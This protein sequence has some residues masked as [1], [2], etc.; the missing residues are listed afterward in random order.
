MDNLEK[1]DEIYILS[2]EEVEALVKQGYKEALKWV[3]TAVEQFPD[4]DPKQLLTT[5]FNLVE[6]EQTFDDLQ[7]EHFADVTVEPP[8]PITED[9]I[10]TGGKKIL[11]TTDADYEPAPV[12][13][14]EETFTDGV[15]SFTEA[16]VLDEDGGSI[17]DT[18][19]ATYGIELNDDSHGDSLV[20]TVTP[21]V[22]DIIPTTEETVETISEEDLTQEETVDTPEPENV[23]DEIV[24]QI[25]AFDEA[26]EKSVYDDLKEQ[27]GINFNIE[28]TENAESLHQEEVETVE[29]E[30]TPEDGLSEEKEEEFDEE[31]EALFSELENEDDVNVAEETTEEEPQESNDET[32]ESETSIF[33]SMMSEYGLTLDTETVEGNIVEEETTGKEDIE[34]E[35]LETTEDSDSPLDAE[36][37][38]YQDGA[39]EDL[40]DSSEDEDSILPTADLEDTDSNSDSQS[41]NGYL[42]YAEG[43]NDEIESSIFDSMMSEYGLNLDAETVEEE[44]IEDLETIESEHSESA[45]ELEE[46]TDEELPYEDEATEEVETEDDVEDSIVEEETTDEEL[47]YEDEA[48]EEV[49]T[50]DAELPVASEMDETLEA[51]IGDEFDSEE[52]ETEDDV[53]DSIVKEETTDEELPYEDGATEE[54][55]TEDA[56]LPAASEMDETLEAEIG[57][58][59]DSEEAET[60]EAVEDSIVKEEESTDEEL[61]YEDGAPEETETE[62]AGIEGESAGDISEE[63]LTYDDV[64]TVEG[65][66][67]GEPLAEEETVAPVDTHSWDDEQPVESNNVKEPSTSYASLGLVEEGLEEGEAAVEE[68]AA[69]YE[70]KGNDFDSSDDDWFDREETI[71]PAEKE[72]KTLTLNRYDYVEEEL[73]DGEIV[74]DRKY[75][76]ETVNNTLKAQEFDPD[77]KKAKTDLGAKTDFDIKK[78]DYDAGEEYVSITENI[79]EKEAEENPE[80]AETFGGNTNIV[81]PS[82]QYVAADEDASEITPEP[83]I[84]V[85]VLD[86]S[87]EAQKKRKKLQKGDDEMFIP[88]ADIDEEELQ[89]YASAEGITREDRNISM[90]NDS[91]LVIEVKETEETLYTA[92]EEQLDAPLPEGSEQYVSANETTDN[93]TIP[94]IDEE[95]EEP[96]Q[97][98]VKPNLNTRQLIQDVK[99][100]DSL[101]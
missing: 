36:E 92:N 15:A 39:D 47:P 71:V 33:D 74:F 51:E 87:E 49:E 7:V 61:P 69:Q 27:Y 48:T 81:L 89:Q 67:S 23:Y 35:T 20:D 95:E 12:T 79:I 73:E 41:D 68:A 53:E 42:P 58:E 3:E 84:D 6:Q 17:F 32:E 37:A 19:A 14:V 64:P 96:E 16:T 100:L 1:D 45:S 59:L 62:D 10:K 4:S 57:D 31:T 18:L 65:A 98:N 78:K 97:T 46:S 40:T 63:D 101:D 86:M 13:V 11:T 30:E 82:A 21:P 24:T 28:E 88:T 44:T 52:V 80:T 9:D 54:V 94:T 34:A 55:E 26:E 93:D 2:S 75:E 72:T 66:D 99:F 90:A 29:T 5:A 38:S 43:E 56:E 77:L 85:A 91:G 50:E 83:E 8:S 60:E 70:A 22:D 76:S 25:E